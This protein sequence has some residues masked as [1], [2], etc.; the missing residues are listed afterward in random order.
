MKLNAVTEFPAGKGKAMLRQPNNTVYRTVVV[1]WLT[2][3]IASV[4]LATINWV[5]L[6]HR[7]A[8][9]REA[10]AVREN[11]DGILK[12]LLDAETSQRG[13]VITGDEQFLNPLKE[14][15]TTVPV[16]FDRLAEL[17]QNDPPLLKRIMDLRGQA[18]MS[19]SNF[20]RATR[21]R[22]PNWSP[23]AKAKKSWMASAPKSPRFAQ[24]VQI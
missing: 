16:L 21:K 20:I 17:A 24:S 3:S 10:V 18:E 8:A 22:R 12:S 11:L 6:S 14:S 1:V 5:Q 19:S 9:A 23:P 15:Q 7:L 13:F 4:V 2:L